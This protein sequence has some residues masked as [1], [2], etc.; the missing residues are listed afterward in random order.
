MVGSGRAVW[1]EFRGSA[2]PYAYFEVPPEVHRELEQA[3]SKGKYVNL[4]IKPFYEFKR[5][6][7]PVR[8]TPVPPRFSHVFLTPQASLSRRS[9]LFTAAF[10]AA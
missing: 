4:K 6:R 7:W 1:I 2:E 9:V 5:R 10:E 3:K 8:R